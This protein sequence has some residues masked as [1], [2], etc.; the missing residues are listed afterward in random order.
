MSKQWIIQEPNP[1]QQ[2]ALARTLAI[3]PIT[4]SVLLARGMLTA[5][6]ARGW[7]SPQQAHFHDPFLLPD[8][9]R[10][11]DRLHQAVAAEEPLAFYGDYDV[12]GISATSLYMSFFS[13][14]GARVRAYIPHRIR[15]GYGLNERALRDLSQHGIKVLVTSDCGT[16]S[17]HEVQ[18]AKRFGMDVIVT[19]HH[20]VD[21]HLPPALGVLNPHRA[22]SIYPFR[23]L[24]SGALAYKVVQAYAMKYGVGDVS[25][26]QLLDLVGLATVADV[27]PLQDENRQFVRQGLAQIT[28]GSRAGLRALKRCAG[29]DKACTTD[30]LAYKLVPR[31]NAAGRLAHAEL[32][33]RLLT[34]DSDVEAARVADELENL[35]RE[36]Q[37]IEETMK[38]EACSMVDSAAVPG[39][40]VLGSRGWHLGVVGIVA[41]RLVERFN[42]PSV[43]LAVSEDGLAKGSARSVAGFDLHA[44]LSAC[45][46]LLVSFGG[47]P[48]AAGLTIREGSIP[49]FRDRFERLSAEWGEGQPKRARLHIDAEVN[50]TQVDHRVVRE[51]DLLQPF[52]SGNPEPTLVVRNLSVL[53]ARVVGDRHLKVTVRHRNSVPFDGIGFRMGSLPE[54][55]LSADKPVDL[56]FVP[57]LGTW[58]GLDR[59]QL[60]IRDVRASQ[61]L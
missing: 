37:R 59:I 52:G 33:V 42:R 9:E 7:L 50:L 47:H 40:I 45:R 48:S 43:L 6:Q 44:A 36:R 23:D 61:V 2:R 8:M 41:A 1:E 32:G 19:D 18:V 21:A 58:R 12:D 28:R 27:V 60:R 39:A 14:L 17:H 26:D 11:V 5:E 22:D 10:V 57:Q 53:Q 20:Q 3:S 55:G 30:T 56:A 29:T 38:T 25:L 31:I 24:C 13:G 51:L 49:A 35:N 15:E 4:A 34:T 16:T 54:L 46:D